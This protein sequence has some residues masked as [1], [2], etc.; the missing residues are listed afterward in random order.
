[1]EIKDAVTRV[2]NSIPKEVFL[3]RINK[4]YQCANIYINLGVYIE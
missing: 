4:L 2:P 3:E 1:M